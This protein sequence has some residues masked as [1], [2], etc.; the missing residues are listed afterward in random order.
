MAFAFNENNFKKIYKTIFVVS[1]I[2]IA[3]TV[4]AMLGAYLLGIPIL[5]LLYGTGDS[6]YPY[7]A[8]L[9]IIMLGGGF[10]AMANL[11]DNVATVFRNQKYLLIAYLISFVTVKIIANPLVESQGIMGASYTFLI[12]EVVL[13]FFILIIFVLSAIRK[14]PIKIRIPK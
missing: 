8:A 3:F 6:L 10:N 13:F 9:L 11:F 7:R 1:L 14:S 5:S 2:L 12:S 4:V